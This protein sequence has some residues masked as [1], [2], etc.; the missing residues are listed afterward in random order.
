[1]GTT[2]GLPGFFRAVGIDTT[3]VPTLNPDRH[4][5]A[6]NLD[7]GFMREFTAMHAVDYEL[8]E[9]VLQNSQLQ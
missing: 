2:A 4:R 7:P 1:M 8:Y 6:L 3:S 9:A 5:D